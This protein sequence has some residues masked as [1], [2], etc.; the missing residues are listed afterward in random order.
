MILDILYILPGETNGF[1]TLGPV[2]QSI[3]IDIIITVVIR[4]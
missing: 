1:T 2:N 4:K 3:F